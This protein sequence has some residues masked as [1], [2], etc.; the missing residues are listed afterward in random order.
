MDTIFILFLTEK[1]ITIFLSMPSFSVTTKLYLAVKRDCFDD[2]RLGEFCTL[3]SHEVTLTV[4]YLRGKIEENRYR[5]SLRKRQWT[6]LDNRTEN[7]NWFGDLLRIR[8][9]VILNND[10]VGT[11]QLLSI[12]AGTR[13]HVRRTKQICKIVSKKKIV[14]RIPF[15]LFFFCYCRHSAFRSSGR[16]FIFSIRKPLKKLT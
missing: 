13:Y 10:P 15:F 11:W 3:L 5:K 12:S 1:I 4:S 14:A 9:I 8:A 16:R 7:G 2:L 6:L